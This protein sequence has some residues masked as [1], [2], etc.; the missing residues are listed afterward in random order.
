M[1]KRF[2]SIKMVIDNGGDLDVFVTLDA[3]DNLIAVLTLSGINPALVAEISALLHR[4][5]LCSIYSA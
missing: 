1:R 2:T 5:F 3:I 4:V